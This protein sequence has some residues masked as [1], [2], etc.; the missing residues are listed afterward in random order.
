[1]AVVR[2]AAPATATV[3]NPLA[4]VGHAEHALGLTVGLTVGYL[5]GQRAAPGPADDQTVGHLVDANTASRARG[6]P[7]LMTAHQ[8][9]SRRP[10]HHKQT[11]GTASNRGG[12]D[13]TALDIATCRLWLTNDGW[14]LDPETIA[15]QG[16]AGRDSVGRRATQQERPD[17]VVVIAVVPDR[18]DLATREALRAAAD[19]IRSAVWSFRGSSDLPIDLTIVSPRAGRDG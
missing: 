1:M 7:G 5:L 10:H 17:P 2:R 13:A 18:D 8:P 3:G 19:A 11:R 4:A 12:N 16:G 6:P 9:R 14:C 15:N